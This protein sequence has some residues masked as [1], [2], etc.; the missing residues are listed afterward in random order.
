MIKI[1]FLTGT[2]AVGGKE[3]QIT[4]LI[5]NLPVDKYEIHL[6]VKSSEAYY[7]TK[8]KSKLTSFYSLEKKKFSVFDVF[9][10]ARYINQI[11]PDIV[12]S[13]ATLTSHFVAI[14][15]ILTK[16]DF[17][18]INGSIRNAPVIRSFP[19]KLE[20]FLFSFYNI[21]VSNSKA[22]LK[23][24]HQLNKKKRYVIH[25]GLDL[26]RIPVIS[27]NACRERFNWSKEN[28]I[29]IM[30]ACLAKRKD[31]DAFILAAHIC[32]K[33]DKNISFMIVGDGENKKS[34]M[35]LAYESQ[36]NSD[37]NLLCKQQIKFLGERTD[38]EE[39]LIASDLSVLMSTNG[40][41][42]SNVIMESM[43]C[44]I[45]VIASDGGGTREVITNGN[46]GYLVESGNALALSEKIFFLKNNPSI[47]AKLGMNASNR[48]KNDFSILNMVNNYEKLYQKVLM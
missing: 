34:L 44:G 37:F 42:M 46:N 19:M 10:V 30:V 25:N 48:I 11:N 23:S 26:S 43:S 38:V 13:W 1:L 14:S 21:V 33:N 15:R 5:A 6:F 29:V 36:A 7:Y 31:F 41:G 9:K 3:R 24:Y 20:A 32:L 4:E 8:I 45:P 12:H 27:S 47:L 40:E 22:G 2:Y 35:S 28:F 17:I 18:L 39:L 16:Q